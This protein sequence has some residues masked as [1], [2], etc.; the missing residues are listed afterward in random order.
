MNKIEKLLNVI[1]EELEQVAWLADRPDTSAYKTREYTIRRATLKLILNKMNTILNASP[2][3]VKEIESLDQRP[4]KFRTVMVKFSNGGFK[5]VNQYYHDYS[6]CWKTKPYSDGGVY[7]HSANQIRNFIKLM[8]DTDKNNL[9]S[10]FV[11]DEWELVDDK[12]IKTSRRI[13]ILDDAN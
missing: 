13:D 2:Y 8:N 9:G 1:H 11:I 7:M 5:L 6:G 4:T 12:H 10:E 3:T